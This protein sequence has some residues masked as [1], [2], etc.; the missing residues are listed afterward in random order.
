MLKR[1]EDEATPGGKRR[2]S[3]TPYAVR[4]VK[5]GKVLS[6]AELLK[7]YSHPP[8]PQPPQPH[9]PQS[10]PPQPC[11]CSGES[12]IEAVLSMKEA[13][14]SM[15]ESALSMKESADSFKGTVRTLQEVLPQ[16]VNR[17]IDQVYKTGKILKDVV[18]KFGITIKGLET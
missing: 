6:P 8:L 11:S 9:P 14:L 4:K 3:S 15:K 16:L 1:V 5:R 13:A 10:Q 12:F 17:N 7:A 2:A 18:R